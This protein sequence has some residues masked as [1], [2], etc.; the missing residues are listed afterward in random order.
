M[1]SAMCGRY[2]AH[3]VE[4]AHVL[5]GG[6]TPSTWRRFSDTWSAPREGEIQLG[7]F[8]LLHTFTGS[9]MWFWS[10]FT[11]SEVELGPDL[12]YKSAVAVARWCGW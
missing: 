10:A 5:G 4:H 6:P 9:K 2:C 3:S 11:S 7:K 1:V 8:V 12:F